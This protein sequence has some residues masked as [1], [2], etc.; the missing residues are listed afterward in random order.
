MT[1]DTGLLPYRELDD[2]LVGRTD[3]E[4][5]TLA[6]AYTADTTPAPCDDFP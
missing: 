6:D 2:A 1:S 4:A 3:T 5:E